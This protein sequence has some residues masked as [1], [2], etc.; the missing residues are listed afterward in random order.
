MY[1]F[2]AE[3]ASM[4]NVLGEN[5]K[6]A[7]NLLN[8]TPILAMKAMFV[9]MLIFGIGDILSTFTKAKL[10]SVFVSLILFLALYMTNIIPHATAEVKN[11]DIITIA[12][13]TEI[14]KWA[15]PFLI[16]HMGTMINLKE[17]IKEWKTVLLALISMIVA[18]IGIFC[19][20]PIL[21][22]EVVLVSIPIINGGIVA[23]KVMSEAAISLGTDV[24]AN[25]AALG[26]LLYAIQKFVGSPIASYVGLKEAKKVIEEYRKTGINPFKSDKKEENTNVKMTFAKKYDKYYGNFVCFTIVAFFSYVSYILQNLTNGKISNTIWVLLLGIIT[27]SLGLVPEKILDRSKASGLLNM[28]VFAAIIP[29]LGK[30]TPDK[31]LSLSVSMVLIFAVTL[32]ALYVFMAIIPIWKINGSKNVTIGIAVCQLIGFP[33]T[34]LISNEIIN[35]VATTDDEKEIVNELI[36][37]RYVIAGIATVTSFSVIA[38]GIFQQMLIK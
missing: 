24:G 19:L 3:N 23:T 4:L 13:L 14:G 34:Y 1:M 25:A 21:G 22:R 27:C 12:G 33:A 20:I 29:S 15:A 8:I 5:V 9:V 26:A 16:F 11:M 17:F 2:L 7:N 38:A 36:M 32:V 30:V 6:V 31:L 37:P 28:A 35:A 18:G 10:S